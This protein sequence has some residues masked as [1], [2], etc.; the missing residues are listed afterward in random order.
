MRRVFAAAYGCLFRPGRQFGGGQMEMRGS[1]LALGFV[2]LC[3]AGCG[4][5]GGGG[6][7][8]PP[9]QPAATPTFSPAAG[10]YTAVQSVSLATTTAG[11]SIY[12]T[13][14]GTTPTNTSTLYSAATPIQVSATT[15][16]K[17]IAAEP[18]A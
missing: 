18:P 3:M 6:T 7:N 9:A 16:I 15:T 4:G 11:A 1:S 17:A 14:D 5:G 2:V 13:L 8:T 10:T 12:Y